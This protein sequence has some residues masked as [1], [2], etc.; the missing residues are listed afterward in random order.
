[1]AEREPVQDDMACET[2]VWAMAE[3]RRLRAELVE[4]L[5]IAMRTQGFEERIGPR[6]G[7][8]YTTVS[9]HVKLIGDR[10]VELGKWERHP[11]GIGRRQWYRPIDDAG[12]PNA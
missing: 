3:I 9:G 5:D 2:C 4:W 10:L 11:D 8:W 1:M 6:R 12:A 7:W